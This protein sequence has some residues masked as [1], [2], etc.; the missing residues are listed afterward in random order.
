[1]DA[2]EWD[3][4]YA[5][6]QRL[7]SEGPNAA[8]AERTRELEPGTAVDLACGE[9]RNAIWLA[10]RGWTVT[11]VD[12]SQVAL[13]RARR[14]A[15]EAGVEVA[16][17]EADVTTWA[18]PEPVDLVVIAYLHLVDEQMAAVTSTAA[19][20]LAPGGR[21]VMVGHHRDNVAHGVGGPPDPAVCWDPAL[22]AAVAR[23]AGLTVVE[24]EAVPRPTEQGDAIDAVVL[25]ARG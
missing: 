10:R 3:E 1:M 12:F 9:G 23:D 25:A 8:V 22:L 13:E 7:W 14:G 21:L 17:V 20:A 5:G 4:R 18:P 24:A 15:V 6:S 16:L 11:G 2:R 19:G